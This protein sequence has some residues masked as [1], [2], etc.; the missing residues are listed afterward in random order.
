[1]NDR[2]DVSLGQRRLAVIWYSGAGLIFLL[3][4]VQSLMG[5][6]GDQVQAAWSWFLPTIVPTL[7]LIT[8]AIAYNARKSDSPGTV[9]AFSFKVSSGLSGFYLVLVLATL[10][11]Q[12]LTSTSPISLMKLSNL[13][14]AP[15]QVLLGIALGAFFSSRQSA[16]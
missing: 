16:G 14:L 2:L 3:L 8:G 12:P 7:S 15:I 4:L 13:W 9:D 10:L 5:K 1:M 6:Y 11:V